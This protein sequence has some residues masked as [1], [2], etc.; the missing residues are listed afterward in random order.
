MVKVVSVK[1]IMKLTETRTPEELEVQ[2][3]IGRIRNGI[4]TAPSRLR[5]KYNVDKMPVRGKLRTK[6]FFGFKVAAYNCQKL[7]R[8]KQGLEFCRAFQ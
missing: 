6:L 3:L 2:T 1:S 4:E 5:N 7:F 8:F